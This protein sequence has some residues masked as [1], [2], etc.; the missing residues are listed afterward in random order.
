MDQNNEEVDLK[1]NFDDDD[2]LGMG[3]S[4]AVFDEPDVADNLSGYSVDDAEDVL[5]DGDDEEYDDYD[6]DEED[7]EDEIFDPD[8]AEDEDEN[9]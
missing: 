8:E 7:G 6:D 5:S 3:R 9:F 1:Q 4:D 2:D